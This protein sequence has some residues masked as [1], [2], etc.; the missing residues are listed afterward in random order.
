MTD[1]KNSRYS[2]RAYVVIT[3]INYSKIVAIKMCT[4]SRRQSE[5]VFDVRI[6]YSQVSLWGGVGSFVV[7]LSG[8]FFFWPT[9]VQFKKRNYIKNDAV[10][11]VRR[12]IARA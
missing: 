6:R 11:F 4:Y 5:F 10:L 8:Y 1:F 9:K 2:S 3:D 12:Y 7:R